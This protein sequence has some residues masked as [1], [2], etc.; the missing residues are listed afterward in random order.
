M[1]HDHPVPLRDQAEWRDEVALRPQ[2]VHE[3]GLHPAVPG[4]RPV[5]GGLGEREPVELADSIDVR[6]LLLADEHADLG[7][8]RDRAAGPPVA[9]VTAV[10][11]AFLD[12]V[13]AQRR[14]IVV[15]GAKQV[16][17]RRL[18]IRLADLELLGH[19]VE[20]DESLADLGRDRRRGCHR[21]AR[22]SAALR[23]GR[24]GRHR[25]SSGPSLERSP[26]LCFFPML[27]T[28]GPL[29]PVPQHC[30]VTDVDSRP[31]L[32]LTVGL[33]GVGKTT[34]A[35]ELASSHR[36][37]RLTPDEWMAPL[38]GQ[39]DADGRRDILEGRMIWVAHEVL[40][41]R[42]RRHPRLRLLV[43]RRAVCHP[44]HR[45]DCRRPTS[46]SSTSTPA[47]HERRRRARTARWLQ[48]PHTTFEM[49]DADHDH[50]LASIEL[51]SRD[52]LD[53]RTR[54]AAA[55]GSRLVAG[56]GQLALADPSRHHGAGRRLT[57]A[58]SSGTS[59]TAA[60]A[61]AA[62]LVEEVAEQVGHAVGLGEVLQVVAAPPGAPPS[63]PASAKATSSA[64][65]SPKARYA[66][67]RD[68]QPSGTVRGVVK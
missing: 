66:A 41:Q 53:I 30:M 13:A 55:A 65:V 9:A 50:Y 42:I 21:A 61:S 40:T 17:D 49:T 64:Y 48:A 34:R 44:R 58:R 19:L 68:S 62:Q 56:M 29:R 20:H 1:A 8:S 63:R 38:F 4:R 2:L 3:V 25:A 52:E 36:V 37:L 31:T 23:H 10:E 24:S 54:P 51:P 60:S 47:R 32:F 14:D 18:V 43:G 7:L 22:R 26:Q 12:E 57:H 35:K 45:R 16:V 39:S 59:A 67:G 5:G 6:G 46:P 11:E 28:E 15:P 27:F 33:P